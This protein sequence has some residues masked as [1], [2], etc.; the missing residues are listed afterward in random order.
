MKNMAASDLCHQPRL[1]QI[2]QQMA[3]AIV[4]TADRAQV[5]VEIASYDP[6]GA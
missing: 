6:E 3:F 1:A 2:E 5:V 4:A